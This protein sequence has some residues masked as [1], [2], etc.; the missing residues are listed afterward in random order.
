MTVREKVNQ[1]I[2]ALNAGDV[3]KAEAILVEVNIELDEAS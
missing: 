1:A 3:E 2:D